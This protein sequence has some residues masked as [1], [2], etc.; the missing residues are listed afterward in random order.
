MTTTT[1]A[2]SGRSSTGL[3]PPHGGSLVDLIVPAEQRE[4][5][6]AGVDR[7]LVR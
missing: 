3:I 4:A 6:K 1:A 7:V 2:P 5:V